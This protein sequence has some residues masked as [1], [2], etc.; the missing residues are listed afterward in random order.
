MNKV[1]LTGRITK[2]PE[3]RRT[4]SGKAVVTF[5]LA[6]DNRRSEAGAD[7]P[8]C[9]AWERT[10]ETIE[11]YVTKG[12]KIGVIGKL[13]TRTYESNGKKHYAT[14]V[15]VDEIEFLEKKE[16]AEKPPEDFESI[17]ED[18]PSLPF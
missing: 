3:L 17:N 6:V 2:N 14:E 11:K 10:A 1:I 12:M 4:Q 13:S 9:V 16:K 18:D 15:V 8:V 5:T 7:F